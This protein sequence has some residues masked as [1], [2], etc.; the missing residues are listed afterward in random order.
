MMNAATAIIKEHRGHRDSGRL[1]ACR[2]R[3]K[4]AVQGR[5]IEERHARLYPED[6]SSGCRRQ[7]GARFQSRALAIDQA[8]DNE[9]NRAAAIH[10]NGYLLIAAPPGPGKTL[11]AGHIV[12]RVSDAGKVVWFCTRLGL[13]AGGA[14]RGCSGVAW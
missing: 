7:C 8:G 1:F 14:I 5:R 6:I 9:Q 4:H 13:N 3:A 11:I 12:E 10:G 2:R